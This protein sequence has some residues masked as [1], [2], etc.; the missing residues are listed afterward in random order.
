LQAGG[1]GIRAAFYVA[2]R[3]NLPK[4]VAREAIGQRLPAVFDPWERWPRAAKTCIA[5]H[6]LSRMAAAPML[7]R[8][9]TGASRRIECCSAAIPCAHSFF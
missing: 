8:G 5:V 6:V 9:I 7:L 3:H 2:L 4:T 1:Y